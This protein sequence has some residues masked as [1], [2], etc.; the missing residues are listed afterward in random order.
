MQL[1]PQL[2]L[3]SVGRRLQQPA[4]M[5]NG[6]AQTHGPCIPNGQ[7]RRRQQPSGVQL[8]SAA[9][10]SASSACVWMNCT[11]GQSDSCRGQPM[12]GSQRRCALPRGSSIGSSATAASAATMML[13]RIARRLASSSQLPASTSSPSLIIPPVKLRP[14]VP[15]PVSVPAARC[16]CC[17]VPAPRQ[18]LEF[19]CHAAALLP[20]CRPVC[21]PCLPRHLQPSP[22][23]C[24]PRP[25]AP[26][27]SQAPVSH[28]RAR[29]LNTRPSWRTSQEAES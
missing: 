1:T 13:G 15:V 12:A 9:E 5:C 29:P 23:C 4:C 21:L 27:S 25:E 2:V 10:R 14:R 22:R 24:T 16:V 17:A 3:V 20:C 26:A 28:P 6:A 8:T 19:C 11:T 7:Q 18:P